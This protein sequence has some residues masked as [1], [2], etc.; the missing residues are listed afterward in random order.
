MVGILAALGIVGYRKYIA[1]AGVAEAVAII[2][3]IRHGE[4]QQKADSLVYLGCSGCGANGCAPGGGSLNAYYPM[5]TPS[6]TKYTWV[7]T[8]HSDYQ[9]WRLLNVGTDSVVRFGYAVVAGGPSDAVVQPTGFKS[10]GALPQPADPWY[11]IKAAGDRN[12]N[13]VFALLVATSWT[14]E[15]YMEE[16]TE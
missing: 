8:G 13:G 3:Q 16:D 7:Q 6:H 9:C 2:Q 4:T 11:V 10:L 12:D 1:S 15:V 14:T 5:A